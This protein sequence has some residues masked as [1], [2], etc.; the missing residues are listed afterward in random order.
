MVPIRGM[1]N[2]TAK[3]RNLL[4]AVHPRKTTSRRVVTVMASSSSYNLA[5]FGNSTDEE[6]DI[7]RLLRPRT[8]PTTI[9]STQDAVDALLTTSQHARQRSL[10]HAFFSSEMGGI[11]T[12][13]GFMVA[14]LDDHMIHRGHAVFDTA[15]VF[16]GYMYQLDAH[17]DRLLKSAAKASIPLPSGMGREQMKRTVLETVAVSCKTNA[18]V[19]FFLSA[20][21]GGFGL[22]HR[23]C[24]DSSFYVIVY[25]QD[26]EETG[27]LDRY[28][29]GYAVKT[30]PVPIKSAFFSRL[31][32]TNY[33]PNVLCQLD[34]EED[35]YDQGI[36]LDENGFI[37]EGPNMNIGIIRS[38]STLVIPP[39]DNAL[40][41][42]TLR[43][44]IELLPEAIE[45]GLTGITSIEQRHITVEEAKNAEEVFLVSSSLIVMPVVRWDSET[46]RDGKPGGVTLQ[47][48]RLIQ[49]DMAPASDSDVHDEVPY[50]FMTGMEL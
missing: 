36:F 22:T 24:V 13:P 47:L 28:M 33:L 32:S 43:R 4:P 42:L 34:A 45:K 17:L 5:D 10:Y 26:E 18:Q 6:L 31:K 3:A 39:F 2:W 29:K 50:G 30:S 20:G 8:V 14:H 44:M 27:P 46:I 19:R 16:D 40:P 41:G 37:A 49:L 38:D 15:I 25:T 21:R 23:L 48:R 12:D 1:V 11:V 9:L 7:S 35:G